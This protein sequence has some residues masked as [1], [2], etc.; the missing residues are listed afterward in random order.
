[1]EKVKKREPLSKEVGEIKLQIE[2]SLRELQTQREELERRLSSLDEQI[3][4]L[5]NVLET[6]TTH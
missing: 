3:G 2:K 6:L 1:M 5:E 4:R